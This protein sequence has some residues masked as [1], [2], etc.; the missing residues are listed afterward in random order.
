MKLK[1]LTEARRQP[2]SPELEALVPQLLQAAQAVY[3]EWDENPDEYAG[4]GI[5]HLIADAI[6]GVFGDKDITCNTQSA[7]QGDQH[8]WC[9]VLWRQENPDGDEFITVYEV[10]IPPGVYETGGGYTWQKIPG[11][12]FDRNDL[13]IQPLCH[14]RHCIAD[15]DFEE[16]DW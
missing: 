2:L 11:V 16:S 15:F 1:T 12:T 8:V 3:D 7:E 14:G 5:C 10:D 4:G 9:N 13:I 6:A